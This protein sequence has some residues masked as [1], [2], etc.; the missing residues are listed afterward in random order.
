MNGRSG[1]DWM[2]GNRVMSD[3]F[4][5]AGHHEAVLSRPSTIADRGGQTGRASTARVPCLRV[6][7]RSRRAAALRL[8]AAHHSRRPSTRK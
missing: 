2:I 4:R 6:T 8:R 1:A 7:R 5:P 3:C